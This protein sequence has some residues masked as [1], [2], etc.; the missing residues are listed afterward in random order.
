MTNMGTTSLWCFW[1]AVFSLIVY[2]ILY[3]RSEFVKP[4]TGRLSLLNL[5]MD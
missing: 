1:C 2:H 3:K 4:R 5:N